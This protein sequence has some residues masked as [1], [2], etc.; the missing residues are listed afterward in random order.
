MKLAVAAL[1]ASLSFAPLQCG[2]RTEPGYVMEDTAGDALWA[3]AGDF[4]KKG[5]S[6]A[7]KAT[8]EYLVA[9]Y[10]SSR[11]APAARDKLLSGKGS[12]AP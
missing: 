7:A 9:H 8:L 10:P 5:D 2:S 11:Y 4:E 6:A 3:L 1:A 12:G